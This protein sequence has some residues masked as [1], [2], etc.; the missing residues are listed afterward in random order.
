MEYKFLGLGYNPTTLEELSE[1]YHR[2]THVTIREVPVNVCAGNNYITGLF[3]RGNRK[4]VFKIEINDPTRLNEMTG[5]MRL[6]QSNGTE[7]EFLGE[8]SSNSVELSRRRIGETKETRERLDAFAVD[9]LRLG[10]FGHLLT[11]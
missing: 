1:Y 9:G 3:I 8:Y 6:C 4:V 2:E 7:L 10:R 5:I 11:R